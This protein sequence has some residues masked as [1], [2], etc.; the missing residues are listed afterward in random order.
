MSLKV[1]DIFNTLQ[2]EGPYVGQ[3]AIF[4]RLADCNLSC[5]FCDTDF[6]TNARMMNEDDIARDILKIFETVGIE[7]SRLHLVITGGEPMLQNCNPVFSTIKA[8]FP[9]KG[10]KTFKFYAES[11]GLLFK[12]WGYDTSLTI[13]PKT[14]LSKLNQEALRHCSALKFLWGFKY[15]QFFQDIPQHL[16]DKNLFIQPIEDENWDENTRGAIEFCLKN[17]RFSLSSQIHKRFGLK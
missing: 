5:V 3:Q 12:T 17:P 15:P 9:K 1:V 2:G 14:P 16:I 10:I 7:G 13:S 8:I 11:N 6:K 4:L